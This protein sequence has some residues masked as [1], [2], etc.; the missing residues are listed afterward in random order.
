MRFQKLNIFHIKV[1]EAI[2]SRKKN[3]A[4]GQFIKLPERRVLN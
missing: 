2:A 3:T 4:A 1:K